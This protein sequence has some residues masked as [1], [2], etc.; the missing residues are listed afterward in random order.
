MY[1]PEKQ[2]RGAGGRFGGKKPTA[3]AVVDD[4]RDVA[5]EVSE[6]VDSVAA[7]GETL[8][9]ATVN[10]VQETTF[11]LIDGRPYDGYDDYLD[12]LAE[13]GVS[14]WQAFILLLFVVL[15]LCG[16]TYGG[17]AAIDRLF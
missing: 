6:F 12:E 9:T 14:G 5:T 1:N 8:A 16:I 15:A 10:E 3:Q 2:A 11:D 17:I 13:A 7:V 4:A